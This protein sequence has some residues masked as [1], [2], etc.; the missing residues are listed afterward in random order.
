MIGT[1]S[2]WSRRRENSHMRLILFIVI[3]LVTHAVASAQSFVTVKLY[4][5]VSVDVPGTWILASQ[6]PFNQTVAKAAK[7]R[8]TRAAIEEAT[9]FRINNGRQPPQ[10]V[11]ITTVL[12]DYGFDENMQPDI[13][14]ADPRALD[15]YDQ[16]RREKV[17]QIASTQKVTLLDYTPAEVRSNADLYYVLTSHDAKHPNFPFTWRTMNVELA[18]TG[19]GMNMSITYAADKEDEIETTLQRIVS[20]IRSSAKPAP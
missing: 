7:S 5:G 6:P 11:T 18:D 12:S 15:R 13:V 9:L 4:G 10:L 19:V 16:D 2:L 3:M 1:T 8:K 17:D 14:A 20:S